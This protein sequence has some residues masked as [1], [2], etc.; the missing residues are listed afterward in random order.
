VCYPRQM[1][2]RPLPEILVSPEDVWLLT[3]YPWYCSPAGYIRTMWSDEN[4]KLRAAYLHRIIANPP[5]GMTVDHINGNKADNRR[6]NLR[7]CSHRENTH[8]ART[9]SRRNKS[10]YIGV[11]KAKNSWRAMIRVDN[12][13]ICLGCH[14]SAEDAARAR[15]MAARHHFGPL[16]KLN[17]PEVC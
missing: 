3:S 15:D 6:E 2:K 10:G 8:G 13:A 11:H 7:V 12:K 5:H 14:G 9:L 17:F 4:G 1:R 16:A